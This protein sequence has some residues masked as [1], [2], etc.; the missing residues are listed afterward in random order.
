MDGLRKQNYGLLAAVAAFVVVLLIAVAGFSFLKAQPGSV[1]SQIPFVSSDQPKS[2]ISHLLGFDGPRTFLVLLLNNTEMRPGGGFIG[3]YAVVNVHKG[4]LL[5]VTV[6]GT[7]RLDLVAPPQVVIPPP[8]PMRDF[9]KL[10]QWQFRDS[11]WS[12][13]FKESA[14]WA[15]WLYRQEGG[16]H[17]DRLDGV[18]GV[19]ATVLEDLVALTGPISSG[20]VMVS[21]GSAIADLEY[22]V[23]YGFVQRGIAV[24]DRK[25]VLQGLAQDLLSKMVRVGPAKWRSL[26]QTLT[27]LGSEKH[28]IMYSSHDQ[29][30]E[31]LEKRGWAGRVDPFEQ[32]GFM[33]VDANLGALKTDH[34]L[35]RTFN[36]A[37]EEEQGQL[38]GELSATYNHTGSYDWRTSR[39]R[40]Y[41]RV[42]IP[43]GA[44]LLDTDGFL[45]VH[46]PGLVVE[47]DIGE[48]EGMQALGGYVRVAPG[49]SHDLMVRYVLPEE[50]QKKA[51]K[52]TYRLDVYKQIGL[53]G[54]QLTLDLN[55]GKTKSQSGSQYSA[56]T[57]LKEDFI[58]EL[59]L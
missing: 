59:D 33:V 18:I 6:Q 35:E 27:D 10:K 45:D 15:L 9:L 44:T 34:A 12:P 55:F 2:L 22:E 30:Q 39:Y 47:P 54:A 43:E 16:Q 11:N 28:L 24:V 29:I 14:L 52:G 20:V 58:L 50:V 40:S 4:K 21:P 3:T 13:D 8:K 51:K 1:I 25:N 49:E 7:E 53:E 46:T 57:P 37:I 48:R 41:T 26:I 31:A 38:V 42:Y 36:Y 5:D 23:E 19:T 56:S 32:D 17:W